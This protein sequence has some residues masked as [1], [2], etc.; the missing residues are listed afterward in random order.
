MNY[1]LFLGI[2]QSLFFFLLIVTNR[3]KALSDFF[4]C[5]WFLLVALHLFYYYS[6]FLVNLSGSSIYLVLGFFLPLIYGPINFFYIK[7]LLQPVDT[8]PLKILIHLIPY[9]FFVII[10]FTLNIFDKYEY[11]ILDGRIIGLTIFSTFFKN[12]G[13]WL[14]IQGAVYVFYNYYLI[15]KHQSMLLE[16]TSNLERISL[17]W[18]KI[19]IIGSVL[20]FLVIFFVSYFSDS[21]FANTGVFSTQIVMITIIVQVAYFG[22]YAIKQT[23]LFSNKSDYNLFKQKYAKSG[24]TKEDSYKIKALLE[25]FMDN[26]RPYLNPEITIGKLANDLDIS[27]NHLSQTINDHFK[28]NFFNYINI[29]RVDHVKE[30]IKKG[31]FKNMSLLGLAFESGFSSKSSFNSVFKKRTKQTPNEYKKSL[32]K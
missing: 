24:L 9:M 22:F 27:Q 29:H 30:L 15:T 10:F 4:V 14:A 1:L 32:L 21:I 5:S 8:K 16:R 28:Q 2:L 6:V 11:T 20:G 13:Y 25:E 18:L 26:K 12:V 7:S 19:F 17:Q 23:N 3:R 31:E